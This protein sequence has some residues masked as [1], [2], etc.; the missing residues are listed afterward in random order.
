MDIG[1]LIA[2]LLLGFVCGAIARALVPNDAFK[3]M[4]GWKSWA[5]STV[6]GLLG[7]LLGYWI[8]TG[9][10][11]IGDEDK[12]DWGGIIGAL[13]GS[14]IVVAVGSAILKRTGTGRRV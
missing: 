11:G 8:F 5:A 9:L 12:F 10:L 14:V 3:A 13:I 6:L 2:A 4:S 1:S 7:A